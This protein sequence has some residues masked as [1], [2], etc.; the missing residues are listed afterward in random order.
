MSFAFKMCLES[1]LRLERHF[2]HRARACTKAVIRKRFVARETRVAVSARVRAAV[3][4]S[5]LRAAAPGFFVQRHPDQ[6]L[7]KFFGKTLRLF[8]ATQSL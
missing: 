7:Q 8:D 3:G 6:V 5:R 1:A 2:T 4:F